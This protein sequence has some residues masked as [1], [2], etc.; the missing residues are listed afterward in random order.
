LFDALGDRA[1]APDALLPATGV[2]L[3]RERML[4]APFILGEDYGT[5]CSTVFAVDRDGH[6]RFVERTFAPDGM[7]ANEV[8]ID[9]ECG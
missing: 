9:F 8:A 6:A 5:R 1:Q 3:E 7:L 4:S 2:T